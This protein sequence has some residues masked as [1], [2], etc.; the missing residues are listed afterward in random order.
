MMNKAK[1]ILLIGALSLSLFACNRNAS[2]NSQ[3]AD[4]S[5]GIIN[6]QPVAK[7][8]QPYK[9]TARILDFIPDG[10]WIPGCTA[11]ILSDDLILTAAHCVEDMNIQD[12]RIGFD[13]QPLTYE[14]QLNSKTRVDVVKKFTTIEVDN[15]IVH[16]LYQ[17]SEYDQDMALIHLKGKIPASFMP[18]QLLS[19]EQMKQIKEKQ[20]YQITLVGFG[21]LSEDPPKESQI[22][23]QTTVPGEFEGFHVVTDQTHGS[24][25]CMGDSGGPAYLTL[26]NQ[27][28]LVGVTH[29]PTI[30]NLDCHHKGVWGNPNFEKAFLNESAQKMGA[31]ARF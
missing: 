11:S 10:Y 24:G 22:L 16:P 1:T 29:G 26:N 6:G 25:G 21:M 28:Y 8:E 18:T 15:Y 31:A 27:L 7:T 23:R 12:M 5:I 9:M 20:S 14:S 4:G 2:V 13:V 19:D 30:D 3:L 17:K